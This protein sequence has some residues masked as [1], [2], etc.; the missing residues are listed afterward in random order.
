M[1]LGQNA[2]EKLEMPRH[3]AL[4]AR[5]SL[6]IGVAAGSRYTSGLLIIHFPD[7]IRRAT[8][9]WHSMS[10]PKRPSVHRIVPVSA[11]EPLDQQL[12]REAAKV[13]RKAYAPYSKFF[14]GAAV[15]TERGIYVGANLENASYGIG[16]C[17]EVSAVTAANSAG[18]FNINAIAVVGY[19]SDDPAKGID[20][21]APCGR[22]RQV[23]FEASQA[24]ATNI[25]VISCNGD[26]SRCKVSSASELL[27]NSFGPA[28]LGI[29]VNTR[30]K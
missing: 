7:F 4:L 16:I 3:R 9:S 5:G 26:L 14:V 27:P 22:C 6:P 17:A 15:R 19:P 23:I 13:A 8:G 29:D 18:D 11:L 24:S 2:F 30:K 10:D 28:N 12:C 1:D 20:I 25:R 21:V